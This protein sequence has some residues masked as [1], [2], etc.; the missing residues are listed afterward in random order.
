VQEIAWS[1]GAIAKIAKRQ[2]FYSYGGQKKPGRPSWRVH[3]VHPDISQMFSLPRKVAQCRPKT[4]RHRLRI[5]SIREIGDKQAQCIKIADQENLYVTNDFIVTHNTVLLG[6]L[7]AMFD[8]CIGADGVTVL[9]DKDRG[10]ELLVRA[11]DGAY[12]AIRFRRN[13]AGW[14]PLRGL[15]NTPGCRQFLAR[16]IKALILLDGL[17][18]LPAEGHARIN[19]GVNAIMRKPTE[20]RSL[21]NLRQYLG[22]Q[23]PS[24]A[25]ARLE[26][27]CRG[28]D[29]GWMFD[30]EQERS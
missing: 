20:L 28:G 24:G 29:L 17:G 5:V 3:I 8:Q 6:S 19:R 10:N 14:P 16:F 1:L 26:R 7:L 15:S 2:T 18:P 12:L 11:V 9:F 22:W 27:W 25:G 13:R 23:D 30:G 21:L 4:M